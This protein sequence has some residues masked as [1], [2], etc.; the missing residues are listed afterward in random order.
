MS[1]RW[2]FFILRF[3]TA[4]A[5][6]FAGTTNAQEIMRWQGDIPL[7]PMPVAQRSITLEA[8][9]LFDSN[10]LYNDLLLGLL[11]GETIDRLTRERSARALTDMN[12][13]G[14]SI[15]YRATYLGTDSLWEHP[16]WRP[17]ISA[18]HHSVL[19]VRFT[20]DAYNLTFFGNKAYEGTTA[21]L[22]GCAHEQQRYQTIGFGVEDARTGSFLRLD[23]VNGQYLNA[24]DLQDASLYTAPEGVELDAAV[25][26]DYWRNDTAQSTTFGR[27]NGWGVAV[28][29]K[30]IRSFNMRQR[31]SWLIVGVEDLGFIR[32][33]D[34]LTMTTDTTILYEGIQVDNIF[35]AGDL[36]LSDDDLLDTLGLHY[37][38]APVMR[39]MPFMARAAVT[40]RFN[41]FWYG[42]LS[43]DQRYMPGYVP[44]ASLAF[45]RD[46]DPLV[47][48]ASI[49]YGGFGGPRFGL[50]V[51]AALSEHLTIDVG[52]SNLVGLVSGEA[53][54]KAA[55]M[56]LGYSW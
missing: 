14:E 55:S 25:T 41:E 40:T 11:R 20:Q 53:R 23:A 9:G 17:M 44:H 6:L 8:S 10:T 43:V 18:A 24:S 2:G 45:A 50:G 32:W 1:D 35:D 21:D 51:F 49:S 13:F 37:E 36:S 29:G 39:L 52:T 38:R 56:G 30:W 27:S 4:A 42:T 3:G 47:A 16:R 5:I 31:Q 26:G 48:S 54:G 34:A 7:R 15:D 28:S 12:R 19:G 22:S 46:F 33:R